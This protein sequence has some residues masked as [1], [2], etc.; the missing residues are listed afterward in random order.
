[1]LDEIKNRRAVRK[2]KSKPVSR[3]DIT[4]IIKAAQFAPSSM[5]TKAWEFLVI[6]NIELKE[7]I[8]KIVGQDFVKEAPVLIVPTM[9]TKKTIMP[10]QDLSLACENIFLQATN[11]GLATVWKNVRKEVQEEVKTVLKIPQSYMI[12]NLIPVG[13]SDE[14]VIPHNDSD[15]EENK[16]HWGSW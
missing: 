9:D 13:Y 7:K 16:I 1:M 8:F 6:E 10:I 5:S 2:Y 11:L 14:E 4:E 12:I 3:K 15:F